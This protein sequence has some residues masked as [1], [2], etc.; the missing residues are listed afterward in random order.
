MTD[1]WVYHTRI[2]LPDIDRIESSSIDLLLYTHVLPP[3]QVA[4]TLSVLRPPK[5]LRAALSCSFLSFCLEVGTDH[6]NAPGKL[7]RFV[8]S[9][10]PVSQ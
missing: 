10:K 2:L 5:V 6:L 7:G 8:P 3:G 4:N 1:E 9:A